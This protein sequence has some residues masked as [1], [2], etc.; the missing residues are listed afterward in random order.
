MPLFIA[1]R[2]LD[3]LDIL[4]VA[5]LIYFIYNLVKGSVAI[6]IFVGI[7]AVYFIWRVVSAL[8]MEM[9]GEILGQFFSVGVI[10]LI[11]VFQQEIRQFLFMM[12]KSGV[13]DKGYKLKNILLG[14]WQI[15]GE[16]F[17]DIEPVLNAVDSFSKTST[18]ALIV[19]TRKNNLKVYTDTG[20]IL[21]ARIST[22]LLESIFYK[23]NTLHDGA[24][25]ISQ[26]RIK[27]AKCVLPLIDEENFP[28]N[29]GLRHRA[30]AGVTNNSDALAV[31]ISEQTGQ[32]AFFYEG[33][34]FQNQS[35]QDIR[36]S[37]ERLMFQKQAKTV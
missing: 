22:S 23:N 34:I 10:A 18:G 25:I 19:I 9:L 29:L 37:V 5:Y 14:K 16:T 7:I 1:I 32:I 20:E 12:G 27:A 15:S 26:N 33:K 24:V 2:F 31:V 35:I 4:L 28:K 11:I 36:N 8:E 6:N 21:E 17:F 30:A 3:V 13:F